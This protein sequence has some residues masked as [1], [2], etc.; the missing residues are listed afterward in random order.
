MQSMNVLRRYIAGD[1]MRMLSDE[2][3]RVGAV[4][5]EKS[6]E[7]KNEERVLIVCDPEKW[8]EAAV[9]FES[10]KRYTSNLSCIIFG[11]MT[12]NAQEP[13]AEIAEAM[14][15]SNIATLATTYSLSH[16][17][18]R[19]SASATGTRIASMPN[20]TLEMMKRTLVAD[21]RTMRTDSEKIAA[22]LTNG[23]TVTI[24]SAQGTNL[25]F[26]IRG[27]A[28]IPDT[29]VLNRPGDFGNLP[30]G[31]AFI[32]PVAGVANGVLIVDGAI[33]DIELDAP[34]EITIRDGIAKSIS[35]GEAARELTRRMNDAGDKARVLCE[36]GIG[37]NPAARL[38]SNVLE[39]EKVYGTCHVA[40]GDNSTFG[41][42]NSIP[43]HTDCV[44]ADPTVTIDKHV[45]VM[46]NTIR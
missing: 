46:D 32:A 43:F 40:F 9:F 20:I 17:Q 11:G 7:I 13:P 33:A 28:G 4:V 34:V 15:S 44:I 38:S 5:F 25:S 27:R 16:T 41:G 21:S 31:E 19:R 22:L 1:H 23:D 35:G 3:K 36:L 29:D 26:S 12:E 8:E 18:A 6:F 37:T 10:A 14:K 2:E 30:A 24:T 39:A 45:I 42:T